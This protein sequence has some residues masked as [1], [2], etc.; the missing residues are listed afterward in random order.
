VLAEPRTEPRVYVNTLIQLAREREDLL[1]LVADL[2][3]STEVDTFRDAFPQR[4]LNLGMPEQ[5]MMGVA[6]G[7][8][9]CGELPFVHTFGV[10]ATRRPYDQVSMSI[11]YPR[12]NVKLV[13]FLPGLTTPGGVTHQAIDDLALMRTL[14]NMTVLDPGDAVELRQVI[15]LAAAHPGPVYFRA[16]R[17]AVPVL[18]DER[19]HPMEIGKAVP[20]RQGTDATIVST[21]TMVAEALQAAA[22]LAAQGIRAAV[23]HSPS[24]KP[25]DQAAVLAAARE[26]G[27]LVTVEN[28]T[29][30]G[31]L[32]SAVAEV[33]AEAAAGVRFARLGVRDTYAE[34]GSQSYLFDKYGL[35]ARHIAAAVRRL[36]RATP[37][38][39]AAAPLASTTSGSAG[40]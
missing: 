27:A 15:R 6:G 19:S 1:C 39:A 16:L 36:L 21:G 20:L 8:A 38:P 11:A 35:S 23:L 22:E 29:I 2:A 10:F 25:L 28:H 26:T 18:F 4:F 32:G 34:G 13:G 14:P 40:V 3:K 9:R 7:L 37:D 17:G 30:I 33:L 12:L 24:I 31:G 5:N